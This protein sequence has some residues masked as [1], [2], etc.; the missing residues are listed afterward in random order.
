MPALD[1]A[2]TVREALDAAR[3]RLATG[4]GA[5]GLGEARDEALALYALLVAGPTSAGFTDA[6][7]TVPAALAAR[8][9]T[10]VARR[11]D[12]WPA[13]YAAGRANFRGHWLAVDP[14]VLIPRPE[15][16]GLVQ[17]VLDWTARRREPPLVADVGTGSGAIAIAVAL[18]AR[19]AGVIATDVSVDALNVAIDNAAALG[20]RERIS[21]RR[22]SWLEP[23]LGE[24]VDAVV[25]NP[26][27]VATAEWEALEPMVKDREPRLALDGG[28]DGLGPT[29]ALAAQA[30]RAL[31]PGGLLALEL[32]ERRAGATAQMLTAEGFADVT[33]HDDLSGRPRYALG[34]RPERE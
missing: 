19:V 10:A 8:L 23:L 12:G 32:D 17:L 26:P 24:P 16:E 9:A 28:A 18:E 4:A 27:Y 3:D 29:R 20:V 7:R 1:L 30:A 5:G 6:A 15:T 13:A 11:L 34:R 31:T 25:S 14:R 21:L 33:V 22:G 2:V